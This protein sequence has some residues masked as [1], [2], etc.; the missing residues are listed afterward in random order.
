MMRHLSVPRPFPF[1]LAVVVLAAGLL[2]AG[3]AGAA[4]SPGDR[5]I[6]RDAATPPPSIAAPSTV[7][8]GAIARETVRVDPT[9]LATAP[10]S[11]W[12]E[13]AP[14]VGRLAF[15]SHFERTAAGGLVWRGRFID[16]DPGYDGITL[17]VHRGLL[18]G[19]LQ[20]DGLEY[21]LRPLG[22]GLS[23]L[24]TRPLGR[25]LGC[26]V[27]VDGAGSPRTGAPP[28]PATAAG[29][30]FWSPTTRAW[31]D[32]GVARTTPSPSPTTPWPR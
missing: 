15:V 21:A 26:A 32:A 2:A 8:G 25:D 28:R 4:P 17:S 5:L 30:P 3:S 1:P 11:L 20:A 14:E 29:S 7:G 22:E 27:G 31:P 12:L 19:S 6:V 16:G 9:V 18:F 24:V 23:S 10:E 13:L